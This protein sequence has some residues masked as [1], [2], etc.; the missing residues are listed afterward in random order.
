MNQQTEERNPIEVLSEDFLKRRRRGD[1]LSVSEFAGMHP[2]H[3]D[4]IRRLFPAMIALEECKSSRLSNSSS[5][6]SID[7]NIASLDQLGDFRIV[8][9]I[10]RGGMGVVYEAEQQSLQRRVAVK[11]FPRQTLSDSKHLDRFHREAKTAAR[12]HHTN[13]VPVFGVGQQDEFHYYVMQRIDGISLDDVIH[14][15]N[16]SLVFQRDAGLSDR[17]VDST[18]APPSVSDL[19]TAALPVTGRL[20]SGGGPIYQVPGT[21]E[22]WIRI[23]ESDSP[24]FWKSIAKV[25]IQVAEALDYAHAQGVVHRDIKPSNLLL[26]HQG[27]VWVTD[28]GLATALE[29]GQHDHPEEVA[30][31]LRFMAPEHL[32]GSQDARSDIY[33]LGLTLYEL[34]TR[35]PAFADPSRT[36]LLSKI[37]K[38]ST[39][40][41]HQFR[42]DIPKDLEAIV[43][44]SMA[45]NLEDRYECAADLASDLRLFLQGRPVTARPI[46]PPLRI[47]RWTMRNPVVASL[48]LALLVTVIASFSIVGT[49]WK[50]AVAEN[51]RADVNLTL[52]LESLDQILERFTDSWMAQPMGNGDEL[53][54][55]EG[56]G[57][58]QQMAVSNHSAAVLQD[59]LDFYDRFTQQNPTNPQLYRDTAKIH[60][61]VADIYQRLGQHER[62]QEAYE[63]SL[64]FLN[65]DQI[66]EDS[67]LDLERGETINQLG[68][69]KASAS[70]FRDAE[71]DYRNAL[72]LLQQ[73]PLSD[74]AMGLA[75]KAKIRTN[76]ARCLALVSRG[77]EATENQRTAV[78]ILEKLVQTDP[79]IAAYQLELARAYQGQYSL[80]RFR[81]R[82][83]REQNREERNTIRLAAT[84]I[85]E[86]LV[87]DYPN[88]PDYRC[89]LSDLLIHTNSS[90]YQTSDNSAELDRAVSLARQLTE[91][92]PSIPRYRTVLARGLAELA[93]SQ[94]ER[95]PEASMKLFEES[96]Q[97][98]EDLVRNFP[99]MPVYRV[100]LVH[101]LDNQA[102]AYRKL[103]HLDQAQLVIERA[104]VEQTNYVEMRS[105]SHFGS[106]F[107]RRLKQDLE[108]VKTA[109]RSL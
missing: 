67:S 3:S 69:S 61:R 14:H 15:R 88:V 73:S 31:T 2:E 22:E 83:D 49:K 99:D 72:E 52:A 102:D 76:L 30:G 5:A 57:I 24:A 103:G 109:T 75:Q 19:S 44:R 16:G 58:E 47:W 97:L 51:R 84:R 70:R 39:E 87:T 50:Y 92:H 81:A 27:T 20:R 71:V 82:G 10:G 55:L 48:C 11:V 78:D 29:A 94:F 93:E 66:A 56:Q 7:L 96:I 6:T 100:F 60:S 35:K 64:R 65:A 63:R 37:M 45:K 32:S 9:E 104:I 17:A 85:L 36:M 26:D 98:L 40:P 1:S 18:P 8:C 4:N 13:I 28:F 68:F 43:M 12:L 41:P 80:M 108:E 90:W 101:A 59:A 79:S 38:G 77:E 23:S 42:P 25:G 74:T 53:G 89:D 46:S 62:A 95:Q 106:R 21:Y 54:D 105:D 34:I 33:S 91:S 86:D 107:L